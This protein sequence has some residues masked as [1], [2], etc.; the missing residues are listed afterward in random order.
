MSDYD[1]NAPATNPGYI[2]PAYFQYASQS[3]GNSVILVGSNDGR[4][5]SGLY[6]FSS[7][8]YL[9]IYLRFLYGTIETLLNG[10]IRVPPPTCVLHRETFGGNPRQ[11]YVMFSAIKM[12]YATW[13]YTASKY[14]NIK[15]RK[16]FCSI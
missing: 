6:C 15:L 9:F 1:C 11:F 7:S 13:N 4:I 10:R 8:H 16:V 14:P 5:L 2:N 12:E 3:G